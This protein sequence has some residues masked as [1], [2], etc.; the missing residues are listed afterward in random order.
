MHALTCTWS[1]TTRYPESDGGEHRDRY[2]HRRDLAR[3]KGLSRLRLERYGYTTDEIAH[4]P[5]T[6]IRDAEHAGAAAR[7]RTGADLVARR[8]VCVVRTCSNA[9][10]EDVTEVTGPG[11]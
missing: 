7:H 4:C 10:L 5:Q 8:H 2:R 9:P 3:D 11:P 1:G 6:I